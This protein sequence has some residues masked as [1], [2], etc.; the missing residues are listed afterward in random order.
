MLEEQLRS[1]FL[2]DYLNSVRPAYVTPR[3]PFAMAG[4][5]LEAAKQAIKTG[6]TAQDQWERAVQAYLGAI[7]NAQDSLLGAQRLWL[8]Q[9]GDILRFLDDLLSNTTSSKIYSTKNLFNV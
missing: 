8:T 3:S 4:R 9:Q 2:A 6:Q 5:G 1:R 7:G